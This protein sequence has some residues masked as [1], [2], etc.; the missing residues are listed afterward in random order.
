[1]VSQQSSLSVKCKQSCQCSALLLETWHC[2]GE[3]KPRLS[4]W[5][6]NVL[7]Y[8]EMSLPRLIS[9]PPSDDITELYLKLEDVTRR[10]Q[11]PCIMDVKIGQKSYDPYA[12]QEKRDQQIK[13]YPLMEEIGFLLLGMRVSLPLQPHES[14]PLGWKGLSNCWC[15]F[16]ERLYESWVAVPYGLF[17][18]MS[19][20]RGVAKIFLL[21]NLKCSLATRHSCSAVI[22]T[23]N[24]TVA[25][26][27]L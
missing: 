16:I 24:I 10:F 22:F 8:F 15:H 4:F 26:S 12:S 21:F 19:L 2:S 7:I 9:A 18:L 25:I 27:I 5:W 1:M 13:K 11:K 17:W 3:T 6:P 20:W 14:L 23:V